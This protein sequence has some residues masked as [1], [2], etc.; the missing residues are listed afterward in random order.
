MTSEVAKDLLE[1][2]FEGMGCFFYTFFICIT[3]QNNKSI[4]SFTFTIKAVFH[5]SSFQL[6]YQ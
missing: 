3:F 2:S 6:L 5:R 4:Y 1:N